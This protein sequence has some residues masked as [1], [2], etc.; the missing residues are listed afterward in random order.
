MPTSPLDLATLAASIKEWARELGFQQA[1]ICEPQLDEQEAHLQR[2]LDAGY[3]GEMD[4]MA[5]HGS[6]RS[7]PAELVPGT[8][9]VISLRMDYLPGDTR[10]SQR[11]AQPEQAYVSRYAL[12]RDYHKLIRKRLQQLAERIQQAIGPFGFR[13]FVDSAPVLERAIARQAGL[14]WV[15]KHS[16]ILNRRAGS[17]FFLGELFVDVPLPVDAPLDS[18]HCGRCTACL[19]ICPTQ[20]FVAPYVLDARRCISYLTIELKGPIPEALRPLIGNRVFGCDDCQIVCPWNRFARPSE[21]S[22]FQPR[23]GLDNSSLAELFLWSEEEFLQRTEGS[24]LR[25]AGYQRWL[26]NLAVGLGNAPS[27]IPVLQALRAR[28]DD[29]S[30]LVREHVAWALRQHAERDA[31]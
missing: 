19:D 16:L 21:Q 28:Q 22:D 7:R 17:W 10:M 26:R 12:G 24:P 13:A 3:H 18:E 2:W 15:G 4:Y 8:L 27:T 25:R 6:K 29:P 30:E 31:Q 20:A 5:A 1:G 9:R 11:L 14:G 23:H